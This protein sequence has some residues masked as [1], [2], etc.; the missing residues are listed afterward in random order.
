M[1]FMFSCFKELILTVWF[2][3]LFAWACGLHVCLCTTC[4][5]GDLDDKNEALGLELQVVVRPHVG[6]GTP[7]SVLCKNSKGSSLQNHPPGPVLILLYMFIDFVFLLCPHLL[8]HFLQFII[9]L[10]A[11]LNFQKLLLCVRMASA[12]FPLV[13]VPLFPHHCVVTLKDS[14]GGWCLGHFS[15]RT[16]TSVSRLRHLNQTFC[17]PNS[18]ICT[19]HP[20]HFLSYRFYF[21]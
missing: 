2:L 1:Y 3:D 4:L 7:A 16:F 21:F 9:V 10:N 12:L 6:V 14:G 18:F 5:S 13:P 15:G 11:H 20:L 19:K 8:L 17:F